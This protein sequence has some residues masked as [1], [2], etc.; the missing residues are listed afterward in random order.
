MLERLK[1]IQNLLHTVKNISRP[2]QNLDPVLLQVQSDIRV[3]A[4]SG[5]DLKTR[6]EGREK[7]KS[8]KN[9]MRIA[10]VTT[11]APTACGIATFSKSSIKSLAKVMPMGT[12]ITVFPLL[13]EGADAD[14]FDD[15]YIGLTIRQQNIGDYA[16]VASYINSQKYD[17]VVL[18]HEF[19][20]WGG[21]SGGYVLC[22]VRLL[23]PRTV[24]VIHTLSDNLVNDNHFILFHLANNVDRVVV[25]S[26]ASRT[27]LGTYHGVAKSHVTVIPHGVPHMPEV[28]ADD[29]A[30]G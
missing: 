20:I 9:N 4:I 26:P 21:S 15:K 19:G 16:R 14:M 12:N 11:W 8:H 10:M 25:M 13:P 3:C 17:I 18:Q 5:Q 22:F 30:R 28:S 1:D 23:L 27:S 24:A 29:D 6:K 2:Q 7:V